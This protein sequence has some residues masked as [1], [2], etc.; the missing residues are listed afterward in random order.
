MATNDSR[1][2][3]VSEP[4]RGRAWAVKQ[5][6]ARAIRAVPA[7]SSLGCPCELC[8]CWWWTAERLGRH[9]LFMTHNENNYRHALA[10]AATLLTDPIVTVSSR[11]DLA[12]LVSPRPLHAQLQIVAFR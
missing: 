12:E 8:S 9:Q 3:Y 2:L 4:S 1:P 10:L 5:S 6:V 7:P 11:E